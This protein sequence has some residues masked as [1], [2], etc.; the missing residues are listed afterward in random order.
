MQLFPLS[1][2]PFGS[3][4]SASGNET[5]LSARSGWARS[6]PESTTA[7]RTPEPSAVDHASGAPMRWRP[8]CLERCGSPEGPTEPDAGA[9]RSAV[10][11]AAP[12]MTA[13]ID[14]DRIQPPGLGLPLSE[15]YPV[16]GD[17]P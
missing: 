15:G 14:L 11:R 8:H 16:R 13:A 12:A 17:N 7:I 6:T 2:T 9:P 4:K 10:A 3:T 1:Q 5:I